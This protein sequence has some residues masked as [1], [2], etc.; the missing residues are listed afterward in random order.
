MLVVREVFVANPGCASKL[1]ALFKETVQSGWAGAC[2]VMTDITGDFNRVVLETEVESLAELEKRMQ[3]YMNNK[4]MHE[5]MKGYTDLYKTG[6]RE[7]FRV[8]G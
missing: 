2:R 4:A 5:K 6:G 7:I 3:E 1:A 8:W